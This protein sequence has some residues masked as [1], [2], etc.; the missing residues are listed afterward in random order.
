[1]EKKYVDVE[2]AIDEISRKEGNEYVH[3]DYGTLGC[4]SNV[5]SMVENVLYSMPAA[6]V[7]PVQHGKWILDGD[8][9]WHCSECNCCCEDIHFSEMPGYVYCPQCGAKM[10][11]D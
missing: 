8:D 9:E 10:D 11:A 7:A 2:A 5:V 1:M 3:I 6:D 4:A